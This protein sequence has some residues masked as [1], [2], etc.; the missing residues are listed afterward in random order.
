MKK[1]FIISFLH[2]ALDSAF[3]APVSPRDVRSAILSIT[4][5]YIYILF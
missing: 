1:T 5:V 3:I 2:M 4:C